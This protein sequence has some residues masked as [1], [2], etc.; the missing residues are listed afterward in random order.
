MLFKNILI[1]I[2]RKSLRLYKSLQVLLTLVIVKS[3]LTIT[4]SNKM[5]YNTINLQKVLL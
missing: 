4:M 2:K 3:T 1:I 5:C